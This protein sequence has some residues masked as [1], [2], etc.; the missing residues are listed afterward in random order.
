MRKPVISEQ[1]AVIRKAVETYETILSL[2]FLYSATYLVIPPFIPQDDRF[3]TMVEK[4]FN[5]PTKATPAG[6]ITE[7]TIFTLIIP[8][9]ILTRVDIEVRENT[10]TM[11]AFTTRFK[12]NKID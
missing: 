2:S 3:N 7:A 4:L 12:K 8:V 11:S 9:S 1:Y 5:C 6:P 10:L